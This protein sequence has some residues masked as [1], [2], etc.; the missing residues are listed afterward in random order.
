MHKAKS[1]KVLANFIHEKGFK[2]I[3]LYGYQF[4]MVD[5]TINRN[6]ITEF[7]YTVCCNLSPRLNVQEREVKVINW[8]P[9]L[10]A[11]YDESLE[12]FRCELNNQYEHGL[13]FR[14]I[15][16]LVRIKSSMV[17]RLIG[18][19]QEISPCEIIIASTK[20]KVVDFDSTLEIAD[21]LK[22]NFKNNEVGILSHISS[23]EE[24]EMAYQVGLS[25]ILMLPGDILRV[26]DL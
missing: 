6:L 22:T 3:N 14:V 17:E 9:S 19:S 1:L 2:A 13:P 10:L 21:S 15:L 25:S 7:P 4:D 12:Q 26:F 23:V 24:L 11:I 8:C 18:A 20:K 5:K 16:D